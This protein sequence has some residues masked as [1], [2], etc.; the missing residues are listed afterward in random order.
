MATDTSQ[1]KATLYDPTGQK[2]PVIVD[3]GSSQAS[4]LQSQGWTLNPKKITQ[5]NATTSSSRNM[6][7][8]RQAVDEFIQTNKKIPS[9]NEDWN[10]VHRMAYGD[11]NIPQELL[12]QTGY[13]NKSTNVPT[14]IT[15]AT[16][17]DPTQPYGTLQGAQ[18]RKDVA[19]ANYGQLTGA[20]SSFI[21]TLQN[22]IRVKT[23]SQQA[24]IGTSE[25]FKKAGVGG[26]GAL[27]QS[28]NTRTKELD[29]DNTNF[30]NTI[31]EVGGMYKDVA[32]TSYNEWKAARDDYDNAVKLITDKEQTLQEHQYKIELLKLQNDLKKAQS[33]DIED[34]LKVLEK[35][36]TIESGNIVPMRTDRHN[37]PTA[38][39]TDLA[40]QAGLIEGV[41]Y[42]DGDPFPDNPNLKT[43]KLLGDSMEKTI[44][45]IDQV[46]FYTKDGKQRWNHTAMSKLQWDSLDQT[47]KE[48]IV[49]EMYKKEG[50][51]GQFLVSQGDETALLSPLGKLFYQ[52]KYVPK[53]PSE[54][55]SLS[56][57]VAGAG[58]NLAGELEPRLVIRGIDT[59]LEKLKKIPN[60][61]RGQVQGRIAEW[62]KAEE[63]NTAIAD[64]K[65]AASIVGMVLTRLFE[66]GVISDA[67]R[68]FY[69]SQMPNL[70]MQDNNIAK[71][72]AESIKDIITKRFNLNM[73]TERDVIKIRDTKTGIIKEFF[74]LSELD[75]EDAKKRGYEIINY[76]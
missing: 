43:A 61:Y 23:G 74:G 53:T 56:K 55:D 10:L 67:D 59:V 38:F 41:D 39:T 34:Q 12:Q 32:Q 47:R 11:S 33:P 28:L 54:Y 7:A 14:N 9:S 30:Q 26:F 52:G 25:I 6:D 44:K 75:I 35:G 70:R 29:I 71:T 58:L 13:S 3:V 65:S 48:N 15:G 73:L 20:K 50:G 46:G 60:K 1:K 63:R 68:T 21:N 17:F 31:Q 72:S 37:N 57:E 42:I 24:G 36:M 2:T 62:T 49:K 19:Q 45:L 22:A 66:K 27:A 40:K 51:S 18:E 5:A 64:F 16:T 76:K 4:Q 69:L 8:E